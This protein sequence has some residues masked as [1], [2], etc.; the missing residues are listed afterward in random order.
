[1]FVKSVFTREEAGIILGQTGALGH[2]FRGDKL[3][4]YRT[5]RQRTGLLLMQVKD[6][7]ECYSSAQLAVAAREGGYMVTLGD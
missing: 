6:L 4:A 1:M 3:E 5:L 2:L 7:M